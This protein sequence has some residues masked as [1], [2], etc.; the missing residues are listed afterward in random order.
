VDRA[1]SVLLLAVVLTACG[2]GSSAAP[3]TRPGA[4]PSVE[5]M[6]IE[7]QLTFS[8]PGETSQLRAIA[9]MSDGTRQDVTRD[10]H[11]TVIDERVG[12]VAP[13]GLLTVLEFGD[14]QIY[15]DYRNVFAK[16][17]YFIKV[18][19]LERPAFDVTVETR[20][21]HGQP[22][23]DTEVRASQQGYTPIGYTDGNGFVDLGVLRGPITV[24]ALH[25]GY[26]DGTVILNPTGAAH[27]VV[28]LV[29]NPGPFVE[30][31]LDDSADHVDEPYAT[32]TY[33][34]VTRAGGMFDAEVRSLNCD[35]SPGFLLEAHSGGVAFEQDTV[36]V[37]GCRARLR[38]IVPADEVVLSVRAYRGTRYRLTYREP[39]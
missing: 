13:G 35:G 10:A 14:T 29:G 30:R 27:A 31:T 9:V 1:A 2:E 23:G 24:T 37:P 20:D 16:F 8:A 19:A 11:W 33:R 25:L 38:F 3:P 39:R 36:P 6:E 17:G 7:G 28:T 34:I 4:T 18:V 26:A 32:K 5:R 12:R 22:L 15:T 21:E